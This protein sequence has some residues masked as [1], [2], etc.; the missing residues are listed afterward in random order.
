MNI[1]ATIK[2]SIDKNHILVST[3]GQQ[4]ELIIPAKS[5]GRGSSVNGGELLFLSLA[6]CFCND[7]YRE[8]AK[9]KMDIQSVEV[10]VS[11]EFGGEGDPA[12]NIVYNVKV[13]APAHSSEEIA[14]LIHRVDNIAEIHNTLRRG[15]TVALKL[16]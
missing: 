10:F 13:Q 2:N 16:S 3:N 8:A 6:T 12:S 7:V 9:T 1:S 11:G 15:A 5:V 14:A 4:R